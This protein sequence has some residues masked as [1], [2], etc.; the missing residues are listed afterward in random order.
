MPTDARLLDAFA[1]GDGGYHRTGRLVDDESAD[2]SFGVA[3]VTVN[4][5]ELLGG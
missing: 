3:T 1:L 4:L 2:L 5:K